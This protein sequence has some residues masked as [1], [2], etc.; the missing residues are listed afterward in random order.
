LRSNS[1]PVSTRWFERWALVLLSAIGLVD[2]GHRFLPKWAM[3]G[4]FDDDFFYYAQVARHL[5][6]GA[7]STFDGI[8]RTNGYHPLWLL[9]LTAFTWIGGGRFFF[10]LVTLATAVSLGSVFMLTLQ[11]LRRLGVSPAGQY[12]VAALI[13]F[14]AELLLQ[15]GMEV[16]L[17]LPLLLLLLWVFLKATKLDGWFYLRCGALASLCVLARL[18]SVLLVGLLPVLGLRE[19]RSLQR[20]IKAF[21]AFSAG[22]APVWA[23]LWLNKIWFGSWM[24]VSAQ[25]KELRLHHTP[26]FAPLL[27]L[28]HPLTTV[29]LLVAIPGALCGVVLAGFLWKHGGELSARTRAMLWTLALF[30]AVYFALLCV[31]SDWPLWYWYFYPLVLACLGCGAA[32]SVWLRP[33]ERTWVM[34]ALGLTVVSVGYRAAYNRSH[35]P[36]K[37]PLFLAARDVASFAES[38]P[39]IYAMGDRGGTVAYLMNSPLIQLE[40]LMM[41]RAYLKRLQE[42]PA[43]DTMLREY[44]VRYYVSTDATL[45]DGCFTTREPLESGPDSAYMIGRMCRQPIAI[46]LHD[47]FVTRVFDVGTA[48]QH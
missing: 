39:G 17:A 41:D 34:L 23:Y 7:G 25:A 47:G 22:L 5:A 46:F 3:P 10:V 35:P 15:G 21:F 11:I 37:N 40:G 36:S 8:H 44:G 24:T 13:T 16:V 27:S 1:K 38:H 33:T 6:Q 14:Q 32:L 48:E 4:A 28:V 29:R 12:V 45:K 43:L 42:R 2:L 20:A 30:P 18:D 26:Q 19:L 31:L 9:C